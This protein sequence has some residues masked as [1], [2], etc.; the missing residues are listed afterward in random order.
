VIDSNAFAAL[1][2]TPQW[3]VFDLDPGTDRAT[4]LDLD[5]AGYRAASFLDQR[6]IPPGAR[7]DESRWSDVA[8]A[9][10]DHARRDAQ[11]IFHI[12]N[13]GSTLISRLLGELRCVFAL[14]EPLL[15]R[16]F[17]DQLDPDTMTGWSA[18]EA[19]TRLDLLRALLSRTFRPEQRSIVKATSFTG[20]IAARVVPEGSR[21]LFL[22]ASAPH[23]LA[24]ILAGQNS[25]ETL[26]RLGPTRLRRLQRRCPEVTLDLGAASDAR[27]AA[28]GWACE[29]TA[30]VDNAR[31]LPADTVQWLDFDRFLAEPAIHLHRIAG[32][33]GLDVEAPAANQLVSGPLMRRYSK[34]LEHEFSPRDRQEILAE[35]HWRH[36]PAIREALVWLNELA[37]RYPAVAAAIRQSQ[38]RD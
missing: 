33:F 24:N 23:Y 9:I 37:A 26:E 8:A 20:E 18:E 17:F 31:Q 15:L 30:L 29:M 28:L 38:Q 2:A 22:F 27:K 36:G 3:L 21:A 6:A 19:A 11:F 12:G 35:A 16:T 32:H 10:P 7:L 5:E 4:L 25:H 34:A 14:R 1:A 13:V